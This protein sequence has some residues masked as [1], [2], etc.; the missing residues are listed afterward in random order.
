MD[1]IGMWIGER[2]KENPKSELTTA[3]LYQDYGRWAEK[4]VGF[5]VSVIAFGRELASRP[6]LRAKKVGG[7][8]G[9]VGLEVLM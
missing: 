3:E 2:C 5:S 9:I 7:H 6:G 1:L 4:E 8:R